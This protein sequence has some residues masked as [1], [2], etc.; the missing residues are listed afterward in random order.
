[1]DVNITILPS[2]IWDYFQKSRDELRSCMHQIASN[3]A[4]GIE[5]CLTEA[6]G[7][8]NIV[9]TADDVQVYQETVFDTQNCKAVVT[10]IYNDFLTSKVLDILSDEP[11][12][13]SAF[14]FQDSIYEREEELDAAIYDFVAAVVSKNWLEERFEAICDDLKEHF[15]EYMARKH[16]ARIY[17]PMIL[18]YEDG[19]E[20]MS[21]YPYEEMIF[22]DPDNPLYTK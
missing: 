5:I 3:P 4:Y 11:Y 2:D 10:K 19:T 12:D 15:L 17:R 20:A 6:S 13:L 18:E 21:E 22:D 14:E 1:M 9:V 8:P 7:F 16:G